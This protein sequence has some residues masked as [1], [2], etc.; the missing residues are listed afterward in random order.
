MTDEILVLVDDTEMNTYKGSLENLKKSYSKWGLNLDETFST[1]TFRGELGILKNFTELHMNHFDENQILGREFLFIVVDSIG[2]TLRKK[3]NNFS[4]FSHGFWRI[5]G[6][7]ASLLLFHK[8]APEFD[9]N[10]ILNRQGT[11]RIFDSS[12][13]LPVEALESLR[14]DFLHSDFTIFKCYPIGGSISIDI[15]KKSFYVV[16]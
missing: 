11:K 14:R 12:Y 5:Y 3:V 16:H 4:M 7:Q 6:I 13:F 8:K 9:P 1:M 10:I 2:D 15:W